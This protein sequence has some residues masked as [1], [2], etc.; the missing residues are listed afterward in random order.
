MGAID[1]TSPLK[2]VV[3]SGHDT[4]FIPFMAAVAPKAW[5]RGWP[6]Y[7]AL[8]SIELL[9]VGAGG[10]TGAG[11]GGGGSGGRA[12]TDASFDGDYFR[13]VYN[14]QVLRLEGCDQGEL[15]RVGEGGG[16]F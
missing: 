4:T 16:G 5:D 15:L 12:L 8:A 11:G 10:G 1:G 3:L 2:F 14:G 9:R 13:F 7:A 6:P